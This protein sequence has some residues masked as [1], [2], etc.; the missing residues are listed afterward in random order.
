M[1]RVGAAHVVVML[2]RGFARRIGRKKAAI[3]AAHSILVI[4]WHLLTDDCD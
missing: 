3:A 4:C 2:V 1:I